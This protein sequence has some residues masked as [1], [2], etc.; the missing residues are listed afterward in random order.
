MRKNKGRDEEEKIGEKGGRTERMKG[1]RERRKMKG[2]KRK[3][4]QRGRIKE[5]IG[6]RG[7]E[8]R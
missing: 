8:D 6:K 4:L 3:K 1:K 7:I 2:K 5:E